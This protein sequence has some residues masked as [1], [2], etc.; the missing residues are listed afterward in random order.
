MSNQERGVWA[1]TFGIF[2]Y[3]LSER[4]RRDNYGLETAPLDLSTLFEYRAR[5][6]L[7]KCTP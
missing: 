4:V 5:S 1:S 6:C 2:A 7:A 3:V